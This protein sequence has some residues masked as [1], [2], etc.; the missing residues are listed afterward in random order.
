M[1]QR[2]PGILFG[3][4]GAINL[5]ALQYVMK[6]HGQN[7]EAKKKLYDY[8]NGKQSILTRRYRRETASARIVVNHARYIT[9]MAV[10]YLIGSPIAYSD[11]TQI[12]ALESITN[13]FRASAMDS[14]DTEIAKHQSIAGR[15]VELIYLNEGGEPR[16]AAIDPMDAFVVYADDVEHRPIMGVHMVDKLGETGNHDHYDITV[17]TTDGIYYYKAVNLDDV[18]TPNGEPEPNLYGGLIPMIE[19]WNND[20]ET[21]DYEGEISLMDAYNQLISDRVNDKEQLVDSILVLSGVGLPDDDYDDA[22]SG[23]GSAAQKALDRIKRNRVLEIPQD[24]DAKYLIKQ[25]SESDTQI[26]ANAISDN[27]HTMSMVPRM[28]DENFAS[29]ASGVAMR[30]K[31]LGFEQMTKVKETWFR[32]GLFSRLEAYSRI[33][34]LKMVGKALDVRKVQITFQRSLPVNELEQAQLVNSLSGKVPNQI[35]LRQLDFVDDVKETMAMLN[36]EKAGDMRRQAHAFD[37]PAFDE[38]R[39]DGN[40]EE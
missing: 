17:Y 24:A 38:R 6:E 13:A 39:D 36:E 20:E 12:E 5:T 8:Y 28:T 4:D 37:M 14:V 35:L 9:T 32:E 10:G 19:Y 2:D 15:G 16:S 1:I 34:E 3:R 26:L 21:G 7:R 18:L 11:N 22:E 23:Q 29:N 31:L 25:L 40:D 30:Y 27:I 33:M